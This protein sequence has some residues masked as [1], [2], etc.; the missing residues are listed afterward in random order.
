MKKIISLLAMLLLAVGIVSATPFVVDKDV[1]VTGDYVWNSGW[2]LPSPK[3]VT[4]TYNFNALSTLAT[5]TFYT[6]AEK[7]GTAWKY[8]LDM[9]LGANSAGMTQSVFNAGTINIPDFKGCPSTDFTQYG[10]ASISE[11]VFS[12]TNLAVTGEGFVNVNVNT[13][14]DSAFT[15]SNHV[16][17]NEPFGT[18]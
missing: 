10:F 9:G 1:L 15:Q 6:E 8:S 18:Y 4:A 12:K 16:R 11:G 14:F 3:P 17:V 2:T 7:L 13:I 5:S